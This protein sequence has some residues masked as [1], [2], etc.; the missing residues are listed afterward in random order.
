ME[1][2]GSL[3]KEKGGATLQRTP[4]YLCKIGNST[5]CKVLALQ[6]TNSVSIP[7]NP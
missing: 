5:A 4:H 6:M 2:E 1:S 7:H 3:T